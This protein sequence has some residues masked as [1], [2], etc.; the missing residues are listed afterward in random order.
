[1]EISITKE[2]YYLRVIKI[3]YKKKVLEER[4]RRAITA[5]LKKEKMNF[6]KEA[7]LILIDIGNAIYLLTGINF[8]FFSWGA[9][10]LPLPLIFIGAVSLMGTIIGVDE[11]KK[12]GT[13]ILISIPL[14][15]V[16]MF[17]MNIIIPY[18]RVYDMILWAFIP[19]PYPH[20]LFLIIGGILCL[21]SSD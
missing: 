12:G 19:F 2:W 21:M 1:M 9:G 3:S 5:E 15:I 16:Y 7:G 6:R 8:Y 10:I 14:S 18:Y 20:S 11:I 13:V 4:L 17:F